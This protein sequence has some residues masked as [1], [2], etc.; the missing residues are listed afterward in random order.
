MA[1]KDINKEENTV[2][3]DGQATQPSMGDKIA[4]N[5]KL[6]GGIAIAVIVVVLGGIGWWMYNKNANENSAKKFSTAYVNALKNGNTDAA[7]I[8]KQMDAVAKS[9]KG[10]AGGDQAEIALAGLY[11][12]DN[13]YQ[14]ALNVLNNVDIDEPIM[15]VNAIIL[16]GDA[17]VGLNKLS[18]ALAQ[19]DSAYNKS[20]DNNPQLAVRALL[21]KVSVLD[22]QKKY[23]DSLAIY[24]QILAD[25]PDALGSIANQVPGGITIEDIEAYAEAERARLGK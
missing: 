24:E 4:K 15:E 11:M 16:K 20:K 19:Y 10:Q 13:E 2:I 5:K 8:K 3:N 6:F 7:S 12:Q 14:K 17:Y 25:Y 23:A 21:K 22:A 9:E 18:D 1:N